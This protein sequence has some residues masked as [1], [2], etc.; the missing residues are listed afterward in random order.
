L[1]V[2]NFDL[3]ACEQQYVS[4]F[5]AEPILPV[6]ARFASPGCECSI[7]F[8]IDS[9]GSFKVC[10]NADGESFEFWAA[11]TSVYDREVCQF[12]RP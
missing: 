12:R 2:A 7:D 1:F 10:V 9:V 4:F 11:I 3:W 8:Q 6:Q 5:T